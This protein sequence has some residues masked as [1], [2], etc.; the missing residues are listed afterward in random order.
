MTKLPQN[1]PTTLNH[2]KHNN[3]IKIKQTWLL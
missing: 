3:N 1:H 2:Q